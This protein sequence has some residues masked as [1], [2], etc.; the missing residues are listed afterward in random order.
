M[1]FLLAPLVGLLSYLG[2]RV[3]TT[4]IAL[5]ANV[6]FRGSLSIHDAFPLDH[7]SP[8][9]CVGIPILGSLIL[10][11]KARYVEHGI[12]GHGIPEIIERIRN[13]EGVIPFR[14]VFI[15]PLASAI[16]IGTGGPYG[17]EG[18]VIGTGGAI[19][20]GLAQICQLKHQD[21]SL[22]LAAGS[23]AGIAAIFGTPVAGVLL[24]I[25][26]LLGKI[27]KRSLAVLL[28]ASLTA[29]GLRILQTGRAPIFEPVSVHVFHWNSL[30]LIGVLGLIEGLAAWFTIRAVD[31]CEELYEKLPVHWM[32]WPLIGA[33]FVGIA[34][35]WNPRLLGPGYDML[36]ELFTGGT[37][38]PNL[39]QLCLIKAV[40]W[41]IAVSSMTTAG[42]LAPLLIVGGGLGALVAQGAIQWGPEQL[43]LTLALGAL[44]GMS[45]YF[46]A[47]SHAPLTAIFLTVEMT[48]SYACLP[49]VGLATAIA[50]FTA[51]TMLPHSI[52][53]AKFHRK[54]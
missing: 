18:P 3:L 2:A 7:V 12:R 51:K 54:H 29:Y 53:T 46:G 48:H 20:S 27:T 14:M 1:I 45:A 28:T 13:F 24:A 16:S 8:W 49:F 25:E 4:L 50:Y 34:G 21:R 22:L 35:F 26:L 5:I 44:V 31:H 39:I 23:A 37:W 6:S 41:V 36:G 52:M 33:S 15:R 17:A 38:N 43:Q 19:G 42:T 40:V 10:G 47:I 30:V 32:W 11:L 9:L